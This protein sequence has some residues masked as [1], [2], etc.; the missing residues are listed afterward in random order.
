[1]SR[2]RSVLSDKGNLLFKNHIAS[3]NITRLFHDFKIE[4]CIIFNIE[5]FKRDYAHIVAFFYFF[6]LK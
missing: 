6:V 5:W 1:M 4:Y 2:S 3:E